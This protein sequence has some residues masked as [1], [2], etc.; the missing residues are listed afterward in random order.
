MSRANSAD[1][2]KVKIANLPD[3]S[4]L[5]ELKQG[6]LA[7]VRGKVLEIGPG[8]GANL[9]YYPKTVEWIGIEPNPFMHAYLRREADRQGLRQGEVWEGTAE[10][11]PADRNSIDAVVSTHVLCSVRDLEDSLREIERILKPGGQFIFLEHVAAECGTCMRKIQNGIE[12]IWKAAF[13][14]CHPNRETWKALEKVGFAEVSYW[15]FTLPFPVVSPHIA[16][17]AKKSGDG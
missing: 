17:V 14:N 11:L 10:N 13:D 9:S 2:R 6:L 16:G 1:L 8:A 15:Q 5:E 7:S 4:N 3:Y 12:P